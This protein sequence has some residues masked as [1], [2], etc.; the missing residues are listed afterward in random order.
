[1][2]EFNKQFIMFDLDG[3]LTD[4]KEG[5]TKSVQYSLKY[6]GIIV[7]NLDELVS[8]IGPPLWD[9]YKKYYN[10]NES[11]A[12]IAVG[13]YREY[14]AEYGIFENLIYDGI[15]NLLANLKTNGKTIIL[16]TSKPAVFAERVL[17][18]FNI[19]KYF[20]FISGAELD[21]R[22]SEKY[23]SINYAIDNCKIDSL[24]K[25]VMIGDREHDIIG[26]KKAGITSIGVLYGYGSYEELYNAGADFIVSSV[27]ELNNFLT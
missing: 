12:N 10:L 6:F 21:G 4:P 20:E 26:A 25:I 17:R 22:R 9:S 15:D 18:Y 19:Y 1:M 24:D 5:I 2:K 11:D 3:T 14:F 8:F 23:E 7:E 13:K 16:A 27:S